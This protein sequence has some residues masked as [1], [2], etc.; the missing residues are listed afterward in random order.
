MITEFNK[1]GPPFDQFRRN[2]TTI[3][4]PD[5]NKDTANY[6]TTLV[7]GN[8]LGFDVQNKRVFLFSFP[9][10]LILS[11]VA[12]KLAFSRSSTTE[13]RVTEY[14]LFKKLIRNEQPRITNG[15]YSTTADIQFPRAS[16]RGHA[17]AA[18]KYIRAPVYPLSLRCYLI[19][20]REL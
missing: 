1:K 2:P 10:A 12:K 8:S 3:K 17:D 11:R 20:S 18:T 16:S 4:R 9:R 19:G 7:F 15:Y 13:Y 6:R 5:S 14:R